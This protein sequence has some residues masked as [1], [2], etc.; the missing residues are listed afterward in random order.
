M[1][2]RVMITPAGKGVFDYRVAESP[3]QGRSRQPLLDA[4]RQLKSMGA[5]PAA[6]CALFHGEGAHQWTVRTTVGKGAEL[7]VHD[8]PKGGRP[9]FVKYE[10]H[11][12]REPDA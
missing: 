9:R 5:N 8:P 11:P 1:I 7:T 10:A 6:Y 12:G 3:V 4:C 2:Y